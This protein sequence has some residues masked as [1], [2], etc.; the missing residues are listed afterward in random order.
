M[1]Q[2]KNLIIGR[3]DH[4]IARFNQKEQITEVQDGQMVSQIMR[5]KEFE[6]FSQEEY[7]DLYLLLID[8]MDTLVSKEDLEAYVQ[9]FNGG[10][11]YEENL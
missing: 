4:M 10:Q 11:N 8:I 6:P 2:E 9:S 1:K 3:I 5:D 7:D